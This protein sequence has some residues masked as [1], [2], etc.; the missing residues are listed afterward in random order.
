[1]AEGLGQ[2]HGLESSPDF[3]YAGMEDYGGLY[4]VDALQSASTAPGQTGVVHMAGT[5]QNGAPTPSNRT[6]SWANLL[7]VKN[8]PLFWLALATILYLGIVSLH[9]S[10]GIGVGRHHH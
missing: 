9:I 7:D 4:A 5:G 2:T 10:A 3:P 1:M 6:S 8:G